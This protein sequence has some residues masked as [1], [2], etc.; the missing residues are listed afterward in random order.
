MKE[1]TKRDLKKADKK[2]KEKLAEYMAYNYTIIIEKY[3]SYWLATQEIGGAE[4]YGSTPL[5]ALE[6]LEIDKKMHYLLLFING[7]Y[8]EKP[9]QRK[10]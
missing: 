4:G 10:G 2:Y 9:K 6:D 1:I 3:A 7:I 8:P 5:K